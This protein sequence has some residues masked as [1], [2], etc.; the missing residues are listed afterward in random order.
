MLEQ[1]LLAQKL[2][3]NMLEKSFQ[4]W[5]LLDLKLL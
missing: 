2:V 5:M 1:I 3:E 4:S